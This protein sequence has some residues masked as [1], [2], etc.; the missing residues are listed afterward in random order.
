MKKGIVPIITGRPILHQLLA[1]LELFAL[2]VL[3]LTGPGPMTPG[4]V[5]ADNT[6]VPSCDDSCPVL[7]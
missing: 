2:L 4:V 6:A 3:G 1:R 5:E 7:D